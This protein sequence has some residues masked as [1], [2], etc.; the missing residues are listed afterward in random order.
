MS[1]DHNVLTVN[2]TAT[3][4]RVSP[5]SVRRSVQD[6]CIPRLDLGIRRV[7]IPREAVDRLLHGG[8]PN[9]NVMPNSEVRR[10]AA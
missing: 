10:V 4:L 2:E 5:S 7:R 3:L 9:E 8:A 6:G 1:L